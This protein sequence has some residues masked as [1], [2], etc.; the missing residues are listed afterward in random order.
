M[1]ARTWN[2]L[3]TSYRRALTAYTAHAQEAA[4]QKSYE[5][6]RRALNLGLGVVD[7]V[8][9][10]QDALLHLVAADPMSR[11]GVAWTRSAE[12]FLM[13]ALSC[14]EVAHRGFR[15]A[16]QRM[17]RLNR[18][19]KSRHRDLAASIG[20]LAREIRRRQ[21]AQ[22][23][24][25]E[26][27]LRFRS[28]VETAQDGIVTV[29]AR[30]RIMA[31]NHGAEVLFG[32]SREELQGKSMTRL[33]PKPLRAAAL[34]ALKSVAAGGEQQQLKRPIQSVG[35]NR[36]RVEFSLEFTLAAWQA[37]SGAMFFTGV[38]RDIRERKEAELALRESRDNYQRLFKEAQAMEEN[39]RQLSNK[40]LTVQEEE[41]RHISCELHDEIGQSL[42]AANVSVAMLRR[43]APQDAAFQQQVDGVQKM[44]VQTI[45]LIHRFARELRPSMLDHLGPVAALQNYVKSFTERTG[46]ETEVEGDV[47]PEQLSTQQGT[48][49]YR[50]AQER[51]TNL[52]KQA[53]A[54]K[55][56]IRLRQRP[57]A[58]SME[59]IDNGRSQLAEGEGQGKVRQPISVLGMRERVRLVNGELAVEP[60]P[61]RG[62][63]VR[64]EIPLPAT[65]V[66]AAAEN[67]FSA[68]N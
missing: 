64:V 4:L 28:V 32:Y 65:P 2:S 17:E 38:V 10:H 20:K 33:I 55:I 59:I 49:L 24:L 25:E 40:I 11:S 13:E 56:K 36:D 62:T 39:L 47:R 54:T 31:M 51:L 19:L 9:L 8:R 21:T 22:E 52:H 61:R 29:D 12:A 58:V 3:Q 34:F 45:E 27:E 5:V 50:I 63:T 43:Q 42:N 26:S 18:A 68:S 7:M 44:L 60:A 16:S 67:T 35:L 66:A 15:D 57:T 37:R 46:I 23:L 30:G 48:V 41:R 53:Q 14:F 6:G 1:K